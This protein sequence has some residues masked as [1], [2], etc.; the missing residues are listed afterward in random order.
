MATIYAVD[1]AEI[2]LPL[3][4]EQLAYLNLP[5]LYR[6]TQNRP[7]PRVTVRTTFA[8]E[9]YTWGGRIVR[10][11]SEIDPV[12]RMVYAVA[13]VRDP[14]A[15]GSDPTRPPLSVGMYIEADIQGRKFADVAV[16]PARGVAGTQPSNRGRRGEPSPLQGG[17]HPAHH[18]HVGLCR[19][20]SD[21]R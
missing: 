9:T 15:V 2:R 4:D 1:A 12:S 21:G 19:A 3:P 16:L 17:R 11:E 7:G 18:D 20:R 10:T 6:G 13:E 14:Y 8:G 5:L